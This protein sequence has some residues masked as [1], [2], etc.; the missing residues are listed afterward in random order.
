MRSLVQTQV[1]SVVIIGPTE[2]Q[3]AKLPS[4]RIKEDR[5]VVTKLLDELGI[6]AE[7]VSM[8]RLGNPQTH[9]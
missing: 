5:T 1:H 4:E 6:E 7:P 9:V 8:Y 3:A 2:Q